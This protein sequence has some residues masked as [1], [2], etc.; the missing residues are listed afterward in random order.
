[1]LRFDDITLAVGTL[2]LLVGA[3]LHVHPGDRVGLVGRNGC[4]KTTLLRAVLGEAALERGKIT[5]RAGARFATLEQHADVMSERSVWDEARSGLGPLLDVEAAFHAAEATVVAG[6]PG[7]D[8]RLASATEQMRLSGGFSLDER[9]GEVLHGLGLAS[10]TWQRPCTAFSGGWR[11]RIALARL[12]LSQ[13]ELLLLDEP[14]N[15]L[16]VI[17][18]GW[19]EGF[20]A[21]YPGTMLVISHDRHLLDAVC[22]RTVEL[23]GQGLH[24]YA[25]GCSAWRKARALR[26]EQQ[27]TA[28]DAQQEE[29]ARLERFVERFRAKANKASQAQSRQKMLDKMDRLVAPQRERNAFLKLPKP[30]H[31]SAEAVALYDAAIGWPDGP[32]V[33]TDVEVQLSAGTRLAV[34]GL[35]G[36]GKS[37]LLSALDGTLPL[38]KGRRR[39]GRGVR[40]A[41]YAQ[42][43]AAA[44]PPEQTGFE[45]LREL[46]PATEESRLRG[47]LGALGLSGDAGLRPISA[48]SGG[49]KARVVLAG[50]CAKPANVLLMDEPTNHLDV[51]TVGVLIDAIKVWPGAVV[52]VSHDRHL[53]EQLATH[54]G[55]VSGGR[56][57][58]REGVRPDDFALT[59]PAQAGST[60]PS[61]GATAFADRKAEQRARQKA[62]RRITAIQTQVEADEA[63]LER[64]DEGL[65]EPGIAP[66]RIAELAK[67][68]AAVEARIEALYGE[69][70]GLE[71]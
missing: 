6:T 63:S 47:I 18:R 24:S 48:L 50:F 22:T 65:C 15:H 57:H 70:E 66:A 53:V 42:H 20:L 71:G 10:E 51:E 12:L 41:R 37:T 59:P 21:R 46:A 4:G 32:D 28:Y 27:A 31:C 49:E 69:W 36:S 43:L 35:N 5:L 1:M 26:V 11:V 38:R 9:V 45:V 19:L 14:T 44:L 60:G 25:G 52:V 54:V 56:L 13:P 55:I 30:P 40:I 62:E 16:D 58:I 17:A 68:R 2:D 23:T 64:I 39:V 3:S 7:S 8:V 67:E 34:L 61:E 33:L 29:I